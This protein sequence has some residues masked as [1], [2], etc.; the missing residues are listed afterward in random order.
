MTTTTEFLISDPVALTGFEEYDGVRV[1]AVGDDSDRLLAIGYHE[2]R[3]V[4]RAFYRLARTFLG[5]SMEDVRDVYGTP[6]EA[7]DSLV[8]AWGRFTLEPAS[9]SSNWWCDWTATEEAPGLIPVTLLDTSPRLR[10][11]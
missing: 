8:R 7:E 5:L 2:P 6:Q 3:D 1:T 11:S 4:L 10:R 9:P